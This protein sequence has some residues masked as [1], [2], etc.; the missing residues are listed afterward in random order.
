MSDEHDSW[1]K[2]AFGVDLGQAVQ[3]I[4]DEASAVVGQVASTVTQVVQGVQGA[5]EG[6][7]GE[8]TGAT[9]GVVKKFAGAVSPSD[10]GGGGSGAGGGAGSFPLRGSVGRGGKNAPNDVRAVQAAL[11]IGVDGQCGGQTIAAIEAFQRNTGRAKP[12]GRVDAGGP[13]E[14]ALASGARSQAAAPSDAPQGDQEQG[15]IDSVL[16]GA[17]D[18][19]RKVIVAVDEEVGTAE[20]LAGELFDRAKE[21]LEDPSVALNQVPPQG[22]GA[23]DGGADGAAPKDAGGADAADAGADPTFQ[24][25]DRPFNV[26]AD[27]P[28]EFVN[29]GNEYLGQ[30][31]AGHMETAPL[32]VDNA[33]TDSKGRV[34]RA[35][36]LV[37][38]TTKRPHWVAGRTIG[39]E[40]AVIEQA[41][42]LIRGHEERHRE[43]MK[44][45][46]R[47]AVN[48]MRGK[49]KIDADKI[50]V[51]W[52][53]I[54][55]T[56]Q[57]ALDAREGQIQIIQ[58]GGR[59][60]GA[61]LVPR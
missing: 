31:I 2:D 35:N 17:K 52:M 42:E 15:L 1:F 14:R 56:Q 38:T 43:I 10:A 34:V 46:M 57:N 54:V 25:V 32:T 24:D 22:G 48:E 44:S 36:L 53:R 29:R 37:R 11:G 12:D 33:E 40:K 28:A 5:V 55:D 16:E 6:M 27:D 9:A 4:K 59:M 18:L 13:T 19:G 41:E 45:G 39:E 21:A 47:N 23:T 3:G 61:K 50:L 49:S 51:K 20:G 7:I 8:V 58:S 60:T 26:R 30:G